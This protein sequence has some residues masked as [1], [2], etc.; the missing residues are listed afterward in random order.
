MPCYHQAIRDLGATRVMLAVVHGR[1]TRQARVRSAAA[2]PVPHACGH[3]PLL[4]R[5][6]QLGYRQAHIFH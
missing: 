6:C 2:F 4:T 5:R 1:I 3:L